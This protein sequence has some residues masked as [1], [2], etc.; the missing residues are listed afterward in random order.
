MFQ[1]DTSWGFDARSIMAKH[2]LDRDTVLDFEGHLARF[3]NSGSVDFTRMRPAGDL[4]ST[5]VCLAEVGVEY[6]VFAQQGDSRLTVDLTGSQG[7]QFTVCWYDP[8]TGRILSSDPISG[9]TVASLQIPLD[10]DAVL[11]LARSP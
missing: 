3:F 4:S 1:N 10:H 8:R 11:H 7:L 2:A 5:G 9:G 6:V